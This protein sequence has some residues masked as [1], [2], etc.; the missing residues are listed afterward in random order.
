MP[1]PP[2]TSSRPVRALGLALA[3]LLAGLALGFGLSP[4]VG[5]T[6]RAPRIS[7]RTVVDVRGSATDGFVIHH[8]D[9]TIDHTETRSEALAECLGYDT[10]TGRARCRGHLTTWYADLATLRQTIRY[11]QRLFD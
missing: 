10:V 11:Y 4:S 3:I 7:G 5:E 8:L 1:R 9:G 6:P 2:S